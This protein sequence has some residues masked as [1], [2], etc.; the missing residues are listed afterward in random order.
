MS[1]DTSVLRAMLRLARHRRPAEEDAVAARVGETTAAVRASMRRLQATGLVEIRPLCPA[2]LTLSGLA[3]AIALIRS[4][5]RR[6]P[7]RAN[8]AS[9][10]A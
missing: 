5:A 3:I 2:R 8:S 10:A 7:I 9:R 6:A 4:E 1:F